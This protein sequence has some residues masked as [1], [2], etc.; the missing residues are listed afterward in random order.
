MHRSLVFA[1]SLVVVAITAAS[2]HAAPITFRASG[3]ID[4]I[5]DLDEPPDFPAMLGPIAVGTLWQLDVTFESTTPGVNLGPPDVFKYENAILDTTFQLGSFLYTRSDGDISVNTGL[6]F[7]G[8]GDGGPGLV[9][10]QWSPGWN[11]PVGAP[12]LNAMNNGIT[13][14]SW[15][16]INAVDGSLPTTPTVAAN[17]GFLSGLIWT[18][19]APLGSMPHE[20]GSS[21]V[22][23][24]LVQ[25]SEVPEPSTL[26][27]LGLGVAGFAVVRRS[28]RT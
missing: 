3:V 1:L 17:Q 25:V 7:A 19:I 23:V 8:Y 24:D 5:L 13:V 4:Y 15:N 12:D 27:M 11:V 9:Q 26:L 21:D 22:N 6:V 28:R 18:T 20:F 10:F 16:D 14:F 2:A